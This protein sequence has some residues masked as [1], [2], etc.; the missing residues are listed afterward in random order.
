MTSSFISPLSRRLVFRVSKT[1]RRFPT[2]SS[3]IAVAVALLALGT[4]LARFG[5]IDLIARGYG[6]LTW[7]FWAVYLL[8]LFT[9]GYLRLKRGE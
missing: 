7:A 4:F 8:P 3:R 5:L 9:V 6:T 2:N 1:I